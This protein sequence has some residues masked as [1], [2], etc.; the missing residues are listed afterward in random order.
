MH[1]EAGVVQGAKM[2]L[3]YV[4]AVGVIGAGLKLAYEN[5]KDNGLSSFILKSLLSESS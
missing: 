2:A 1:I 5:I 3:S 4:T